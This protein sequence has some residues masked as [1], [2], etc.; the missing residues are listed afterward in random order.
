M[1]YLILLSL[2]LT[3]MPVQ[4][5]YLGHPEDMEVRVRHG[6]FSGGTTFFEI[7]QDDATIEGDP[8]VL[9]TE[10]REKWKVACNEWKK[11]RPDG[12]QVVSA[13]CGSPECVKH[14]Y[15]QVTCSSAGSKKLR[16]KVQE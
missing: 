6:G 12:A 2:I 8:A 4:A 13:T 5:Q 11:E 1:K 9:I 15:Y 16:V 14:T 10:A 7:I 3:G